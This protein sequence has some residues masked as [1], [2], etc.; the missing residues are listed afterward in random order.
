MNRSVID[1]GGSILVVSQFTLFADW[2]AGR[3]PGFTA[4][5]AP[6]DGKPLVRTLRK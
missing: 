3:R 4:A 1:V 5:A 6:A 2:K